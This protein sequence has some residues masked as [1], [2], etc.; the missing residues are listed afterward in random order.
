MIPAKGQRWTGEAR[1]KLRTAIRDAGFDEVRFA[2]VE[3]EPEASLRHWLEAGFHADM[4]W[5]AR[6]ADKRSQVGSV[7]AGERL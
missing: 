2:Q 4:A 1:E 3:A 6:T 7:L 5:M